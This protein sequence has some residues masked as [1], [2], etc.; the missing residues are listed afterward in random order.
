M[1]QNTAYQNTK[2][3]SGPRMYVRAGCGVVSQLAKTSAV[4]A[5]EHIAATRFLLRLD[6]YRLGLAHL[7][8]LSRLQDPV[9]HAAVMGTCPSARGRVLPAIL[10]YRPDACT[11]GDSL[12]WGWGLRG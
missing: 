2:M 3:V 6:G 12:R 4:T 8:I 9:V 1:T 7:P 10:A 11:A 5:P